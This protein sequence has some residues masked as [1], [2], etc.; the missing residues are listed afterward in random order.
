M[1]NTIFLFACLFFTTASFAQK[2][3]EFPADP[4]QFMDQLEE[5]MTASKRKDLTDTFK[6]FKKYYNTGAFSPEEFERIHA[7]SN[8]ML[9]Y[10]MTPNP[11]FQDYFQTLQI[12]KTVVGEGE[13]RFDIWHDVLDQ[14]LGRIENRKLKPYKEF[15]RFSANFFEK[16]AIRYSKSGIS[17]Y[18]NSD[19][20]EMVYEFGSPIIRYKEFDLIGVRKA[21][22]IMIQQ[23]SGMFFVT[24]Q[25]WRGSGGKVSWERLGLDAE[26]YAELGDYEFEVKRSLYEVKE[27]KLYYPELFPTGPIEGNFVDKVVAENKATEGSYPRFESRDSV[28][29]IED[30]GGGLNYVGGFRLQGK[31]V[32]GY[33]TKKNP[34]NVR[35]A[36]GDV[37]KFRAAAELFVIRKGERISGETVET[38]LYFGQDSIYHPSVNMRFDVADSNLRLSRGKRGSD[39]N[40]FYDSYHKINLDANNIDWLMDKDTILIGKKSISFTKSLKQKAT[41]ESFAYFDEN[42][43]HRLQNISDTNPIARLK[44]VAERDGERFYPASDLA[45]EINPVYDIENAQSLFYDLVAKGFINYDSDEQIVEIKDKIFHYADAKQEKVDYDVLKILSETDSINAAFDLNTQT[46]RIDA[47]ASIEFSERQK[48]AT[49]P[50]GSQVILGQD[51]N[52][53]FNGDLYAGMSLF[54]GKGFRFNYQ[55]FNISMDSVRYFDLYI[56]EGEPD[57]FGNRPAFSMASRI[58]HSTGVLLIDAPSN[59]SG[60]E[61]IPIFPSYQSKGPSYVFYDYKGTQDSCYGRDSFYFELKKF[62]FNKI[63]NYDKEDIKFKGKMYSADIFPPFEETILVQEDASLGFTTQTPAKGYETYTGKG[64]Y[65]GEINLSNEG[66][67]AKGNIA[68]LGASID[69]EDIIFKPKQMLCSARKFDLEEDRNPALQ[70]PQVRGEDVSIDWQPYR[71]SMYVR[72]EEKAF[73]LFKANEHTLEGTIILTPDGVKG[74]GLFDWTAGRLKSQLFSFGAYSV[75]GDTTEVQIKALEGDNFAFDTKNVQSDIDFDKQMGYFKANADDVVTTMPYNQYQ[76][77]LNEFTWKMKEDLIE[78]KS[79]EEGKLGGFISIHPD[80]DSLNFQGETALYNLKSSQ[81]KIGGVPFIQASDARIYPDSTSEIEILP[82]GVMATL[83]NARI[84]ADTLNQYHVIKRATVDILGKKEYRATGYYEYNIGDREQEILFADVVGTRVGK[85]KRSEKK[86]VTQATGEVTPEDEFFID[87]KTEYRGTISLNAE[88]KNLKFEGFARLDSDKLLNPDWFSINSE[89]DKNNLLISYDE[90][91]NYIGDPLRNGLYLSKEMARIY[92]SIMS[93]LYYRKDRPIIDIKGQFK[94]DLDKDA[95]VFGDSLRVSNR[96][97]KGNRMLLLNVDGSLKVEGTFNLGTGLTNGV[98]IKAVGRAQTAFLPG[99]D[100]LYD[101]VTAEFMAGILLEMPDKLKKILINDI[102]AASFDTDYINYTATD[103]FYEAAV[104]QWVEA[105][106]YGGTLTK[107]RNGFYELPKKSYDYTFLFGKL[108]MRWDFDYQ[109]F[110]SKGSKVHLAY[111]DGEPINKMLEC[112]VEFKMPSND[113]D[114]VYVYIKS[115]S[116][117]YYFFGYK[118]GVLNIGSNN[119]RF[120]DAVAG[121]KKKERIVKT[122]NEGEYEILGVDAGTALNFVSRIKAAAS[123]SSDDE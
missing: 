117:Y 34:A 81:L 77:T 92:P 10:K 95:F 9:S 51:R 80:Q 57:E 25:M 88:S 113:D 121:L 61:D 44:S 114:R 33:G 29:Q 93:P 43:Y 13:S 28:L 2:I 59:K 30:I 22:T 47:V 66:F 37:T 70:I 79:K 67:L 52:I 116:E 98:S 58:E 23:T 68:Y 101:D 40:P 11:Y 32:Y 115:P 31:T 99:T 7:V 6:A 69:S 53:E 112:Y 46:I 3:N 110:V 84:V 24:E 76:T 108:P 72:S 65:K 48:V 82:G 74:N 54:K 122:K 8:A 63:D 56:P 90:P 5:F 14:V 87:H 94:Y 91:K 62:S 85:G 16:K 21:D 35:L 120:N 41:F 105:K 123:S 26:V 107:L 78:F 27:A 4:S 55:A 39:R 119:Q 96:S 50:A 71:D 100:K 83:E 64:Q 109:S 19:D 1:K 60:K 97:L 45:K 86:S 36:S 73:D 75:K 102:K 103:G 104:A 106:K 111:I 12:V 18:S 20:Y 38:A 42:D 89:A 17:W 15:L 118:Q 49:K